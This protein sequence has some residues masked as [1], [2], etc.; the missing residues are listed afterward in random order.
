MTEVTKLKLSDQLV[1]CVENARALIGDLR[2]DDSAVRPLPPTRDQAER[3][4]PIQET[5][6]IGVAR[7]EPFADLS[8]GQPFRPACRSVRS[9]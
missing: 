9:T 4:Q 5:R 8:T 2:A 6:D 1:D 7:R 3:F